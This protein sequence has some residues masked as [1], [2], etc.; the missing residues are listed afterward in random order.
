MLIQPFN[1]QSISSDVTICRPPP[2]KLLN[3]ERPII[4]SCLPS[5]RIAVHSKP[6]QN[7]NILESDGALADRQMECMRLE[8]PTLDQGRNQPRIK[9]HVSTNLSNLIK[10]ASCKC[11]IILNGTTPFP[12]TVS[13]ARLTVNTLASSF[14]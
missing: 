4:Y 8:V 11:E 13:T 14:A 10:P 9:G 7:C 5:D 3:D 1:L 2:Q 12:M 6:E